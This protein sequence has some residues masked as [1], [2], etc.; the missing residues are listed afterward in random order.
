MASPEFFILSDGDSSIAEGSSV[1]ERETDIDSAQSDGT[2]L[3][4]PPRT[5]D[6]S[7]LGWHLKDLSSL[8]DNIEKAVSSSFP[9]QGGSRYK[10]V[11]V[12]LMRWENGEWG[13]ERELDALRRVSQEEYGFDATMWVIPSNESSQYDVMSNALNF[14]RDFD[15]S[16]NLF[17]LYYAGH[18]LI[19]RYRQSTWAYSQHPGCPTVE[20][21]HIQG[22]FERAKSDV[23]VLLDCC[24][25]AS[26]AP[27]P[28][29]S[30][31]ETLAACGFEG[32]APP[33]GEHSFTTSL[34]EV[35]LDWKD[36]PSFSV[37][38][39]HCEVLRVLMQR[40]KERCSNGQ[41]REWRSTPVY[42]NGSRDPRVEGI[43]LCKR[44]LIDIVETSPSGS[45]LTT[46]E[47]ILPRDCLTPSSYFDLMSLGCDE[48]E[49]SLIP[50]GGQS[51][52]DLAPRPSESGSSGLSLD[53]RVPHMLVSIALDEDQ[54][55]PNSE[56]CRRWICGFPGLAKHVK[57]EGVY[58]SY[59]TVVMLS[60]P[61]AVYNMLPDN[62][63][64]QPVAY[65]TSRNR[66]ADPT[67]KQAIPNIQHEAAHKSSTAVEDPV[68]ITLRKHRESFAQEHHRAMSQAA[69]G[70]GVPL[71]S[72]AEQEPMKVIK[73]DGDKL[74]HNFQMLTPEQFFHR[75]TPDNADQILR[76]LRLLGAFSSNKIS[77]FSDKPFH[78]YAAQN[79]D[80]MASCRKDDRS[81]DTEA[82]QDIL[83]RLRD[84]SVLVDCQIENDAL[85]I[86]TSSEVLS[87]AYSS[88]PRKLKREYRIKGAIV[89][90][91]YL[92]DLRSQNVE[93]SIKD[94]QHI[95]QCI[96]ALLLNEVVMA[97]ASL[98]EFKS[99][100]GASQQIVWFLD[101]QG[102]HKRATE[103]CRIELSAIIDMYGE[104]HQEALLAMSN[105]SFY[106]RR[107]GQYER[108]EH[109]CR[110]ALE[111]KSQVL[112]RNHIETLRSMR[113]L[114]NLF[115][116]Q[117]KFAE[118]EPIAKEAMARFQSS[119]GDANPEI[120]SF[121]A[122]VGSILR[123][124][125]KFDE[126]LP[127]Y[128][129]ISALSGQTL[130][131]YHPNTLA[132][133]NNYAFLL[134]T[135]GR[136]A[137]AETTYRSIE[138]SKQMVQGEHHPETLA[139]MSNVAAVCQAQG[140]FSEAEH[141][142]RKALEIRQKTMGKEHP[143]TLV[144]ANNLAVV[145]QL[146]DKSEEAELLYR[147]N[148]AIQERV[149]GKDHPD[150]IASMRNLV[151]FLGSRK[152]SFHDQP[153][154]TEVVEH[155]E[156]AE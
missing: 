14:I 63:A 57:V 15:T 35:L 24:A 79:K 128:E 39:L 135:Q 51:N 30:A 99:L 75:L 131:V 69:V 145:L 66:L 114:A 27:A 108:A 22:L 106:L 32:I 107:D 10:S 7:R 132:Y 133:Y 55:L 18:G 87:W 137:E 84:L 44:T 91:A 78:A 29:N 127:I 151:S 80:W 6:T 70:T 92:L 152:R 8:A 121:R 144:V 42:I 68:E 154:A 140:K 155:N 156:A 117:G 139:S 64:C 31:M 90:G 76:L 124:Q 25:A 118:A 95:Q 33:P 120:L 16:D 146:Q 89:L 147:E 21:S 113:Q 110:K 59:S 17:I 116:D 34:I 81:W 94:T 40:R 9:N 126:A 97:P 149:L 5:H 82:F 23:L 125:R 109:Y 20:W 73:N 74:D 123:R 48:L 60:I 46:T 142:Y 71:P 13:F 38:M 43:R 83:M 103:L 52:T 136:L 11:H 77:E 2:P 115:S 153:A 102:F 72:I 65:V 61:V 101:A 129:Q 86:Q 111:G 93:L 150:T 4:S 49:E 134:R 98:V 45:T 112:A 47:P 62:P 56:A 54:A 37:T 130:G 19:N 28:S 141:V 122:L 138:I 148:V 119:I 85:V 50:S 143:Q 53:L 1:H 26:S 12:A 58:S 41:K 3:T 100:F 104:H 67:P 96:D 105:L 36:V 88:A